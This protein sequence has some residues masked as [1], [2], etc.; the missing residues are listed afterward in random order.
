[1]S[2]QSWKSS[3]YPQKMVLCSLVALVTRVLVVVK[4]LVEVLTFKLQ[5]M[6]K[7][8]ILFLALLS[9]MQF[10][11]TSVLESD[12]PIVSQEEQISEQVLTIKA[13]IGETN[14]TKTAVQSDG[15]SIYWTPGDAINLFY[16]T[17]SAGQFTTAIE[18]PALTTEFSGTLSVATGTSTESGVTT[19]SFWGVYPYNVSNTCT[20]DGVTLTIPSAQSGIAGSF[21]DKLNPSVATSPGLSLAFYNV[22]SWFIFSVTEPDIVSATLTGHNNEILAGRVKVTMDAETHKPVAEVL[23]GQKSITMTPA[24]GTFEVGE[25]Y[26]MVVI[27]GRM[28]SGLELTLTKSNGKQATWS[29]NSDVTFTRSMYLRKLNAD[30]GLTFEWRTPFTI[31]STG[32]TTV[33]IQKNGSP[34]DITLEYR[35][36][37]DEWASYTIGSG[38]ALADG[39]S[40]QFRA[41]AGG[42]DRFGKST[43]DYYYFSISGTG[44]IGV[45]GNIMSILDRDLLRTSMNS[46]GFIYLF[47][48]CTK[49][50][51][52][53]NLIL[54][55]T[56]LAQYCYEHMFFQCTGLTS[57]PALPAMTLATGCYDDMFYGC[58]SL[59]SAPNLPATTLADYCYDRM[60]ENC[61]GLTSAPELPATTLAQYCYQRMFYSCRG[62]TTAPELPATT[63]AR[64][65][66][67]YMFYDCTSLT[68]G[69]ELPATTLASSCYSYMFCV[70]TG[71]TSAPELPATNL[72]SGCYSDMFAGCSK[73]TTAPELPA[74]TL[75][76]FC[77]DRMF[78]DCSKLNYIKMLATNISASYCLDNWVYGVSAEG[79]FVKNNAA[80]WNVTGSSGVPSGWIVWTMPEAVDLGL[81]SG[82]K[83][84]SFNIGAS[85]PEECGDYYAWGE[86]TPYYEYGYAQSA[87]PVWKSGK[88]EG[89]VWDSYIWNI[90]GGLLSLT[91]YTDGDNLTVLEDSDDVAHQTLRGSWRIPTDEE[92]TEL[93]TSCNRTWTTRNGVYGLLVTS[94]IPG[95][96]SKSIFLP[97]SGNRNDTAL[98]QFGEYGFYWSSTIDS[99]SKSS[100]RGVLF[101]QHSFS[102]TAYNRPLG[103]S[104]RPVCN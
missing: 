94:T 69:P 14:E 91:K 74:T 13:T 16:G 92:W 28:S 76:T 49:L 40:L 15:V 88:T 47:K 93:R 62:L 38:I 90:P 6:K 5:D 35:I 37:S 46:Y 87:D 89:Y 4:V 57:A 1:M 61:T 60:F 29:I 26:Y 20:G 52:A 39:E 67:A 64:S 77:Y 31:T 7:T 63:M 59:T 79:T 2:A 58:T 33:T 72:V 12:C 22:G 44:T 17:A 30:N 95:Y 41:G 18:S 50:V 21:A 66:Y 10:S 51:R 43:S 24:G 70:C 23:E 68:T 9:W 42:N 85:A 73:L 8:S 19:Q 97:A 99:G 100:A 45:C 84:A 78:K 55:A 98:E 71:L 36:D 11:C 83:W 101:Y 25:S 80:S 102:G 81:P 48:N 103:Q 82:T 75:V 104:I 3:N 34:D 86:I 53:N 56:T 27:P 96:T 54:P 65:C 32:S